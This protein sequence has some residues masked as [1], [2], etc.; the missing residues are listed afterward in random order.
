M[1]IFCLFI[2]TDLIPLF[3]MFCMEMWRKQLWPIFF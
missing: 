3:K 1:V 2:D